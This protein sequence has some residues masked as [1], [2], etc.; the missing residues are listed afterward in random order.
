MPDASTDTAA[1]PRSADKPED[2][3]A[4]APSVAEALA[5][6]RGR[7]VFFEPL[8]GNNGDDLIKMGAQRALNDAGVELVAAPADAEAIVIN[9]GGGMVEFSK[10][11]IGALRSIL[12]GFPETPLIILPQSYKFESLDF[13]GLF[14]SRPAPATLFAR[15]RVS[16]GILDGLEMP[17]CVTLGLD[18]DMAFNLEGSEFLSGLARDVSRDHVLIVERGDAESNTGMQHKAVG[19][20]PINRLLPHGLKQNIKRVMRTRGAAARAAQSSAFATSMV[21]RLCETDPA[22]RDLPVVASDVS[23]PNN[24]SFERFCALIVGAAAVASNRLHVGVLAALLGKRTLIRGA[25]YHKIAGI[26]E[27]SLEGRPGVELVA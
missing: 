7:R 21:D 19:F 4:P 8:I 15:E 22:L 2:P 18:H 6:W 24:A 26:W 14:R 3:R 10:A 16:L 1:R 12:D 23:D 11:G 27:M 25:S 20:K 13:A 5:A 9:G 17:D